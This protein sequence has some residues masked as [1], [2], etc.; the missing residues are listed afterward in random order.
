VSNVRALEDAVRERARLLMDESVEELKRRL[1]IIVPDSGQLHPM[2]LRE[3]RNIIRYESPTVL[4]ASISYFAPVDG[5]DVA[6]F[7]EFGT[8]EHSI[9]GGKGL[10][11]GKPLTF[12][13]PKVG[14]IV[15]FWEV[16][17][18]PGPGVDK[19]IG[20]F[21]KTLEDW[22]NVVRDTLDGLQ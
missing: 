13:W 22:P 8:T 5:G 2:K 14:H 9:S 15:H 12:F 10:A 17:W 1:D 18:R 20:W 21:S 4:S 7:T 3:T 6:E 16:Q 19:N 11:G